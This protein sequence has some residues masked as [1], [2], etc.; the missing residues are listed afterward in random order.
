MVGAKATAVDEA[1]WSP[2]HGALGLL[3]EASRTRLDTPV[4]STISVA[5]SANIW[6][7]VTRRSRVQTPAEMGTRG[8]SSREGWF[9][10][11]HGAP[12]GSAGPVQPPAPSFRGGGALGAA[13]PRPCAR[14]SA[15]DLANRSLASCPVRSHILQ[16][17]S[18]VVAR[19]TAS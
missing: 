2:L 9:A 13:W 11:D 10:P 15:V 19:A 18:A 14:Q 8:R 5:I 16:S 7:G 6:K 4:S 1:G 3:D 17:A 12:S